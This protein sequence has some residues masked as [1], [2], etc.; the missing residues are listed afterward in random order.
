MQ[1]ENQTLGQV[2][3]TANGDFLVVT[4]MCSILYCLDAPTDLPSGRPGERVRV[5]S[6]DLLEQGQP[7]QLAGHV[8]LPMSSGSLVRD[9]RCTS[10]E[11]CFVSMTYDGVAVIDLQRS[12]HTF[13]KIVAHHSETFHAAHSSEYLVTRIL[14]GAQRVVPSPTKPGTVYT[15]GWTFSSKCLSLLAETDDITVC[16]QRD[17]VWRMDLEGFSRMA[18]QAPATDPPI[19]ARMIIALAPD[20]FKSLLPHTATMSDEAQIIAALASAVLVTTERFGNVLIHEEKGH[21]TVVVT[22]TIYGATTPPS[23][24]MLFMMLE[25]QLRIAGSSLLSGP[26]AEVLAFG[27]YLEYEYEAA[28]STRVVHSSGGISEWWLFV[29]AFNV[30]VTVI[31][32]AVAWS[33][34]QKA[35]VL[36]HAFGQQGQVQAAYKAGSGVGAA[37][38]TGAEY[39]FLP[40]PAAAAAAGGPSTASGLRMAAASEQDA[41]GGAVIGRPAEGAG[42]ADATGE[43]QLAFVVGRPVGQ[44]AA[45]QSGQPSKKAADSSDE[46]KAI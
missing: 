18:V 46:D 37:A 24:A 4:F 45:M 9:I 28:T 44:A 25:N 30:V 23:P 40:G 41:V 33:Y 27:A 6:L 32:V 10:L 17:K 7:P 13:L 15:E 29:L 43:Q 35:N 11:V 3:V 34:R 5:Y 20:M 14:T 1:F 42:G 8:D 16:M 31:A 39:P 2:A 22:F 36:I 26:L 12:S 38:S 21:N 19:S